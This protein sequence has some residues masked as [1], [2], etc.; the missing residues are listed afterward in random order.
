MMSSN[1]NDYRSASEWLEAVRGDAAWQSQQQR[2]SES[3]GEQ[4]AAL[5][6]EALRRI[7]R[8]ETFEFW[9]IYQHRV[10]PTVAEVWDIAEL[11]LPKLKIQTIGMLSMVWLE[12][13]ASRLGADDRTQPTGILTTDKAMR[14]WQRAQKRGWVDEKLRPTVSMKKASVLA[15]VMGGLL[16]LQ[17]PWEP[18]ERLWE[19]QNL[20][21]AHNQAT[22]AKYY[23]NWYKEVSKT[24]NS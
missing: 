4:G 19:T 1:R 22:E 12:T 16:G 5:R 11:S 7:G 23:P 13:T 8:G 9:E 15:S 3:A 6:E 17:K 14:L 2:L 21:I 24:L 10:E 20:R 18:F